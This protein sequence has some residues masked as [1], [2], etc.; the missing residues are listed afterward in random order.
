MTNPYPPQQP[1]SDQPT[2][3]Y[4]QASDQQAPHPTQ[5]A[6][7]PA[8]QPYPQQPYVQQPNMQPQYQEQVYAYMPTPTDGFS[9][10]ALVLGLLGFNI[11]AIVFG[12]IGL[13]R[14]STG[15]YS[16]RGMAIAGI[17]L[18]AISTAA[19][20]FFFILLFGVMGSAVGFM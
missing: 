11:F 16:G 20:I 13:N 6:Y 10:A 9:V 12:I 18:G 17:V 14:T 8:G 19:I 15:Q 4:A 5:T 2:Q 7:D 1:G 3:P